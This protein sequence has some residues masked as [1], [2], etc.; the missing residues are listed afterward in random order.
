MHS[1]V[2]KSTTDKEMYDSE[3]RDLTG[4]IEDLRG[5]TFNGIALFDNA[6]GLGVALTETGTDTFTVSQPAVQ[7]DLD[8]ITAKNITANL[9]VVVRRTLFLIIHKQTHCNRACNFRGM[10]AFAIPNGKC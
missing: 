10:E 6:A 1:D 9:Q 2:T 3:F 7:V 5:T 4:Q 8:A